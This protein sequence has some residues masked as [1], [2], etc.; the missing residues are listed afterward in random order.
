MQVI[1]LD[2]IGAI[3]E[4]GEWVGQALEIAGDEVTV[5]EAAAAYRRV[6]GHRP[7]Y[8][9]L[10]TRLVALADRSAA[11]MFGSLRAEGYRADI[12]ALH[13]AF[14]GLRDLEDGLSR[15]VHM[16]PA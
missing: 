3:A 1:A 15:S 13:R 5:R 7:R 2:D 8:L 10:P 11:A 14:P 6:V 16:K 9:P 4:P 12:P